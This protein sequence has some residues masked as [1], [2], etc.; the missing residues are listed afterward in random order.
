MG[1]QQRVNVGVSENNLSEFISSGLFSLQ[2]RTH[3]V[4]TLVVDVC[5]Y[6]VIETL[7]A[8]I[9]VCFIFICKVPFR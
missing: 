5:F 7:Q 3:T 8:N 4:S 2:E 1:I 6:K 9:P